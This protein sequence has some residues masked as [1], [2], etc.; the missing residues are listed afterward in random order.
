MK[1]SSEIQNNDD[2]VVGDINF[3]EEHE[4]SFLNSSLNRSL[5]R[6]AEDHAGSF[7]QS[8][9]PVCLVFFLFLFILL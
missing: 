9:K 3:K 6:S 7:N 4:E 1:S 8:I 2:H 5:L